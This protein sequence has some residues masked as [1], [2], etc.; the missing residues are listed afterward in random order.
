MPCDI[1][2]QEKR[3]FLANIEGARLYVCWDCNPSGEGR[4]KFE[5]KP[6][7]VN[8][9]ENKTSPQNP[10]KRTFN[11][12]KPFVK[13]KF[14]RKQEVA[15]QMEGYELIENYGK[16]IRTARE[17]KKMSLQDLAKKISEGESY[18]HGI[19]QERLKPNAGILLK[20]NESLGI[21]LV[22]LIQEDPEV[23][24]FAKTVKEK[25]PEI[26]EATPFRE[27]MMNNKRK[28]IL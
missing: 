6:Q 17:A 27:V 18:L 16:A 20:L 24:E 22:R 14:T 13:K 10:F 19:E 3:V 23:Q 8:R 12:N 2:G 26:K 15:F 4:I 9:V 25:K 5:R 21:N 1:C 7:Y 28:L 11:N